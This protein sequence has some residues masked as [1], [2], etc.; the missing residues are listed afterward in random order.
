ME[1]NFGVCA[2]MSKK[3]PFR[4]VHHGFYLDIKN[5]TSRVG[6]ARSSPPI[7]HGM[8]PGNYCVAQCFEH[9]RR[10][11]VLTINHS[12]EWRDLTMRAK[13]RNY[14]SDS[15]KKDKKFWRKVYRRIAR[16]T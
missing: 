14:Q 8:S 6:V 10:P 5:D 3:I 11:Y 9:S 4:V 2:V 1:A 12:V 13:H 15:G 7:S 16:C